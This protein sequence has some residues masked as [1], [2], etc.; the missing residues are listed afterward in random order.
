M[1]TNNDLQEKVNQEIQ[2][3]SSLDASHISVTA[4]GGMAR[5]GITK[6]ENNIRCEY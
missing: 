4:R 5:P 3:D 2:W 6:I 1:S